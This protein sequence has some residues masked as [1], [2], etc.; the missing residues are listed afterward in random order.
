MS[1]RLPPFVAMIVAALLVPLGWYAFE[2]GAKLDQNRLTTALLTGVFLALTVPAIAAMWRRPTD[3]WPRLL[4]LVAAAF[5]VS[6]FRL[7]QPPLVATSSAFVWYASPPLVLAALN[8]T[9]R[10]PSARRLAPWLVATSGLAMVSLVTSGPLPTPSLRA[11]SW[12]YFD[13]VT[14]HMVQQR[15]P[16]AWWAT[17]GAAWL[18]WVS[19][20]A[21]VA[22]TAVWCLRPAR[23]YWRI[24]ATLATAASIVLAV[25]QRPGR[26]HLLQQSYSDLLVAT[27]VIA[28]AAAAACFVWREMIT[29]RLA[30]PAASVLRLD[31]AT[32][33]VMLHRRLARTVGDPSAAVL[34]CA[35]GRWI[36]AEGTTSSAAAAPGRQRWTLVRDGA[37]IAALDLDASSV[38]TPD[39][40]EYAAAALAPSLEAQ[41]LAALAAAHAEIA[42]KA[43]GDIIEA[44]RSAQHDMYLLISEG[45]DATLATVSEQLLERPLPLAEVHNGLRRSLEQVRSIARHTQRAGP[46]RSW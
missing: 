40:V 20:S 38:D 22:A 18:V 35:D 13:P 33:G 11:A 7:L 16:I 24:G 3:P 17:D 21:I 44:E 12:A 46:A 1:R 2:Q 25:P 15:N 45:P 6:Y 37:A 42:R 31:P 36:S 27:P 14:E 26:R 43:A 32:A 9:G 19:W 8:G 5:T 29:P 34:F 28:V 23:T 30:R 10:A 4:A 39:L 41:R